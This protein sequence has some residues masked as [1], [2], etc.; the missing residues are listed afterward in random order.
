MA[1]SRKGQIG[2]LV[3]AVIVLSIGGY[4]WKKANPPKAKNVE[5]KTK[6]T[7]LPPLAYDKNANAEFRTLPTS[8]VASVE[9]PQMRGHLMEWYAQLGLLYAVGGKQTAIGSIC[10]ELKVNVA[11]DVQN[12]CNIQADDLY[13][14]ADELHS[15]NP[16]PSKGAHF[17]IWMGDGVP[18]YLPGLNS[19][20]KKD[21]G[22]EYVAKV[23]APF[24]ASAGEDKWLLKRKYTKDARGSLTATVL[25]DGD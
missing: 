19:R 3:I 2:T 12:D 22:D 6:A 10:E 23:V 18:S 25:R 24:G 16:N 14:F 1:L 11:L 9:T 21:F 20:L 17:I 7:S 8:D 13:A 5:V 4:L 15:G